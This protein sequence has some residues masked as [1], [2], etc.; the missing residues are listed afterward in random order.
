LTPARFADRVAIVTG[1]G[2]GIGLAIARRLGSEGAR[3]VVA[4]IDPAAAARAAESARQAG[5]PDAWGA[6]CDVSSEPD[7]RA[8]VRGA[9]DR[10]H[11][12]DAIVNNAGLMVFKPLEDQTEDDWLRVLRVDL[13]GAFFFTR[14]ALR[15]MEHGGAI[16]NVSSIH[17]VETTPLVACYAAAKAALLSLTRS[18]ALE[19][20]ARR[21]R[22]NA[23]LPGAVDTPML[24]NNPN[25]VSGVEQVNRVDVGRPEDIASVVAFLASDDAQFV[26]GASLRADG[27]RLDHL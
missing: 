6:R 18:T 2:S 8:T 4:D 11:R 3:I 21:I 9:I 26:Q 22:A 13:L 10:W 27:G 12:L 5:A 25:I 24:W 14:E 7:V 16:V 20:K 23:V 15:H 17:A 19:G 1:G